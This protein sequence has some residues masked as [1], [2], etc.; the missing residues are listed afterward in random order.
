[1]P[2]PDEFLHRVAETG[3]IRVSVRSICIHDGA[4]LVQRHA[5][6][7]A[8]YYAFIGGG[9]ETG[10]TMEDRIRAEY[11]EETGREVVRARYLF[12]VEN[13]VRTPAGILH[14]LEH[15]FAVELDSRDVR[16]REAHLVQCW[17]PLGQLADCD[18]RP[19]VVRDAI[20][21]GSWETR[22]HLVTPF[23]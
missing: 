3:A 5:D 20:I 23:T 9:L 16:S 22:K 14:S 7:P 1:M 15:Y 12:V 17:L 8:S 11:R 13:R 18:L 19:R 2:T 4:L 6:D 21:D 10:E